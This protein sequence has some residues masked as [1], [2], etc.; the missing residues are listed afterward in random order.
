MPTRWLPSLGLLIVLL[1]GPF[2]PAGA[3]TVRIGVAANFADACR[4]LI[5]RFEASTGHSVTASY[6][7]TGKLYAQIIHGAPYD[8]FMAADAH[9]PALL[10]DKGLAV[11]GTRLSYAQGRL[12]LWSPQPEALNEPERYLAEAPFERL[13]IANPKTAP[14]GLAAQQALSG[15]ALWDP[16]KP[17]LVRGESVAQAF[18]FVASGNA[19][20]GFVAL[21][22][23]QVWPDKSGS[24]WLVP[25]SLYQPITQ[26][27][28]LLARGKD[29]PAAH[30]WLRFLRN[31]QAT[32][33][34]ERFGYSVPD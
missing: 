10:E 20:A 16:L 29:N 13:A 24:T 30:A 26:Q 25:Q 2:S 18:Q 8:L 6:G 27:A 15:L 14:Y 3:D 1:T 12:A 34:I 17:K 23:L 4:E 31:D 5:R 21:S 28:V 22:Q 7:S 33:I 9:R 32:A 11:S 19:Q